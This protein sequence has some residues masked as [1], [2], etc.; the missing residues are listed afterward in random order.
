MSS[1]AYN[2]LKTAKQENSRI[3]YC[4][5]NVNQM[6]ENSI[7]PMFRELYYRLLD[8][9]KKGGEDSIIFRHHIRYVENGLKYYPGFNYRSEEPNQVVADYI[10]SMT[11]DYFVDLH[12]HLFPDSQYSIEYKSYFH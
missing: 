11:D 6:Y 8:D 5:K 3:I 1:E 12:K 7:R 4:N 2:D 9:V 10:A